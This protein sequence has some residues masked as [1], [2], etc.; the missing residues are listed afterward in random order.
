MQGNRRGLC[1][2]N[3][4]A[5]K[6][7]Q[8]IEIGNRRY[9]V[10]FYSARKSMPEGMPKDI[11]GKEVREATQVVGIPLENSISFNDPVQEFSP[12]G[13]KYRCY[14]SQAHKIYVTPDF[15]PA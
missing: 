13:E 11:F 3:D 14:R 15:I 9:Y 7:S 8:P 2:R 12:M 5:G 1:V 4:G 10:F 6:A